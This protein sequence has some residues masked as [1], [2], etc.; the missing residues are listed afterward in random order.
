MSAATKIYRKILE[1]FPKSR[2]ADSDP[3]YLCKEGFRSLLKFKFTTH[4]GS[5]WSNGGSGPPTME[6]RRLKMEL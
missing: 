4:R 1:A 5:K 2:I 3:H 6:A